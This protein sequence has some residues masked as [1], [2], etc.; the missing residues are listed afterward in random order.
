ME[1]QKLISEE[2][3]LGKSK[4]NAENPERRFDDAVE[5]DRAP[6]ERS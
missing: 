4:S 6:S 2:E 1:D 5:T 3:S